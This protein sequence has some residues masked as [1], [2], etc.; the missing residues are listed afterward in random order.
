[1]SNAD[2]LAAYIKALQGH[3]WSFNYTDDQRVWRRGQ[4]S[5][6]ALIAARKLIDPDGMVWNQWAPEDYRIKLTDS[7]AVRA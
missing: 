2:H 1:M 5:L 6:E 4:D 3:D 7:P